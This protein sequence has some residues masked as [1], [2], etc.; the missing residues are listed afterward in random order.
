MVLVY[1]H[2]I[3]AAADI[4]GDGRVRHHLRPVEKEVVIVEN[5]VLLLGLDIGREKLLQLRGPAGAPRVGAAEYF[6]DLGLGV[7]AARV[8]REASPLCRE[9]ALGLR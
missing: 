4:V 8:D 6:F 3:E 7:D 5:V 2:V 9:T 1:E